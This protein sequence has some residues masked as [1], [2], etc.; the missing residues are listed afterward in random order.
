MFTYVGWTRINTNKTHSV[1]T[2]ARQN[3]TCIFSLQCIKRLS[4]KKKKT[5]FFGMT[6]NCTRWGVTVK[7]CLRTKESILSATQLLA[8]SKN[9]V[10][11]TINGLSSVVTF[12]QYEVSKVVEVPLFN[13]NQVYRR[14]LLFSLDCSALPLIRTIKYWDWTPVSRITGGHST[15]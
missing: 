11:F 3:K 5:C 2:T 8:W 12:F 10:W 15:I 6:R 4:A 14:D 9:T 1:T 13:N 7:T